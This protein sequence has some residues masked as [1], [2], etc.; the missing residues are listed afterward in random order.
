LEVASKRQT[1]VVFVEVPVPAET[2]LQ[3]M[4][5]TPDTNSSGFNQEFAWSNGNGSGGGEAGRQF[6]SRYLSDFEPVQCLGKGGF[7]VVFESKNKIDDIHY[8]VKRIRLP[9]VEDDRKKVMREVKFLAK[10]DHKNIVR[11]FNTWLERPPPGKR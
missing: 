2:P 7:G 11:Y 6:A 8:A 4:S 9:E 1:E 5:K 3:N 10:L